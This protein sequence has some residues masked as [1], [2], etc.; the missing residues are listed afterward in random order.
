MNTCQPF[1]LATINVALTILCGNIVL[2]K[3][4]CASLSNLPYIG[5]NTAKLCMGGQGGVNKSEAD[6]E[7]EAD[8]A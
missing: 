6:K 2:L 8:K 3:N 7:P 4:Y 1:T 5:H